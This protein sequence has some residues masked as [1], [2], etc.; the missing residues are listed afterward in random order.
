MAAC[1]LLSI[2]STEVNSSGSS[3][4][5][6]QHFFKVALIVVFVV[7]LVVAV[8]HAAGGGLRDGA[9]VGRGAPARVRAGQLALDDLRL[10][11]DAQTLHALL[12][13]RLLLV[14]EG[15]T[16]EELV[17]LT[18]KILVENLDF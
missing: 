16:E 7:V 17:F 9:I 3:L 10:L 8:L 13:G 1:S 2:S 11:V 15:R 12:L 6:S 4:Q 18:A 5:S 14:P